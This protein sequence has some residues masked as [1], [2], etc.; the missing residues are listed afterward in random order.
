MHSFRFKVGSLELV[1]GKGGELV[2]GHLV[3]L[4]LVGVVLVDDLKVLKE[5]IFPVGLFEVCPG[6]LVRFFPRLEL[7]LGMRLECEKNSC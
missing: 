2:D 5:Y 1:I 7:G 3:S 4:G 6:W